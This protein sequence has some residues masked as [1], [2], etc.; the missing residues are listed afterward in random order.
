MKSRALILGGTGFVGR[1]L[2]RQLSDRYA[3]TA[4]GRDHDIR[5][6]Q[7]VLDLV[8]RCAPDL[9]INL[10]AI[11]T[12]KETFE[13]PRET[14]DIG[15]TGLLNLLTALESCGCRGRVLHV[16]SSEVYGFPTADELPLT[17]AAPLR[18]MSPYSVAKAAGELLCYQW[19]QQASFG[20]VLARPFTHIGP[21]QSTRFAVA[22]FASQIADMIV[23]SRE[24]VIDVGSVR[25][26]RDFTDV[27]DVVR[28][29]DMIL[30]RGRNGEVYNV[31]TGREVAVRDVIDELIRLS[32]LQVRLVE[33]PLAR[34]SSEQQRLRGSYAA[35]NAATGWEPEIPLA[36]TLEDILAS[37]VR[38]RRGR[39]RVG[40]AAV[41]T[42]GEVVG[43]GL[44][45]DRHSCT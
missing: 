27:R 39:G 19:A 20:I 9:V 6:H 41:E 7:R 43:N 28:A 31:C 2:A 16:S 35:L 23:G 5:D 25:T 1:H 36:R 13:R 34:R 24:P 17:E 30:H 11:T 18:P 44:A 42:L 22:N 32:S 29:Y 10:A 8:S 15:F 37:A 21:G 3:V 4:T 38:E 12:V 45:S 33:N 14:Y 40:S 26:S